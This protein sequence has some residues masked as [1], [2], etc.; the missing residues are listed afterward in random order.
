MDPVA[1]RGFAQVVPRSGGTQNMLTTLLRMQQLKED[2]SARRDARDDEWLRKMSASIAGTDGI[3]PSLAPMAQNALASG[4]NAM[5]SI[6]Y[7]S[8]LNG[9]LSDQ[10]RA[11]ISAI[12][13]DI[14]RNINLIKTGSDA[15]RSIL[16][17]ADKDKEGNID[18]VYLSKKLEGL[19]SGAFSREPDGSL[20]INP[21]KVQ[22]INSAMS[23][24]FVYDQT[25]KINDFLDKDLRPTDSM[26]NRMNPDG[27]MSTGVMSASP[28]MFKTDSSG[29][30]MIDRTGRPIPDVKPEVMRIWDSN[31]IRKRML[32][33]W[34]EDEA[35]KDP[36]FIPTV[37]N[38]DDYR[39]TAFKNR[40]VDTR[41][42]F[43]I[44]S[45]STRSAD[46]SS[47][48]SKAKR[49]Q[50]M[51]DARYDRISTIVNNPAKGEKL[52]GSL[53]GPD[54]LV[55]YEG[56]G[57]QV[58]TRERDKSLRVMIGPQGTDLSKERLEWK[59]KYDK[60]LPLRSQSTEDALSNLAN[61]IGSAENSVT[62]EMFSA[63]RKRKGVTTTVSLGFKK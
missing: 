55:K 7:Q 39:A 42:T 22:E 57:I 18:R 54:I 34:A 27:S 40:V 19:V 10:A 26:F 43:Q 36:K 25:K 11:G 24:P 56:N 51:A 53:F 63:A 4:K 52:L 45:V 2:A 23:D 48:A 31:P 30:I 60:P 46:E 44:K 62:P 1:L 47:A 17:I 5:E 38:P 32:D 59:P 35:L 29:A 41:G 9:G 20:T 58:Y 61:E 49:M 3:I 8:R 12:K 21:E 37:G 13:T 28:G 50:E 33:K 14:D 15:V 16:E 6:Y